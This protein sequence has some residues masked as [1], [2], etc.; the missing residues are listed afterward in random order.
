MKPL[1]KSRKATMIKLIFAI[2]LIASS[3][4][5]QIALPQSKEVKSPHGMYT[6]VQKWDWDTPETTKVSTEIVFRD[7]HKVELAFPYGE[8]LGGHNFDTEWLISPDERWILVTKSLGSTGSDGYVY[9]VSQG[10]IT[11]VVPSIAEAVIPDFGHNPPTHFG[12][13]VTGWNPRT[14]DIQLIASADYQ[15]SNP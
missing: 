8:T 4:F 2:T 6:I 9:E 5:G 10:Q 13:K 12:I 7:G 11:T 3:A 15:L 1:W 14:G